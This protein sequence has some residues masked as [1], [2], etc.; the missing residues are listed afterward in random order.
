MNGP[1][2]ESKVKSAARCLK[3]MS[4]SGSEILGFGV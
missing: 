2:R 4:E 1:G 3:D